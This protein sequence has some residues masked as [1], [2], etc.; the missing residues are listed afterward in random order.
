M[1]SI[2]VKALRYQ[3]TV[4]LFVGVPAVVVI[5]W[6]LVYAPLSLGDPLALTGWLAPLLLGVFFLPI[7]RLG[8]PTLSLVWGFALVTTSV[9]AAY[10]TFAVNVYVHWTPYPWMPYFIAQTLA[11]TIVVVWFARRASAISFRHAL[12][13]VGLW[14][15]LVWYAALMSPP[16]LRNS[17]LD[18]SSDSPGH[19]W[20]LLGQW[21][22][23]AVYAAYILTAIWV[24][25]HADSAKEVPKG[26][27][28]LL[29]GTLI[30][31]RVVVPE[32]T[33]L[34]NRGAF[35]EPSRDLGSVLHLWDVY[36][37]GWHGAVILIVY[38]YESL[39]TKL[40][41]WAVSALHFWRHGIERPD[42]GPADS[43]RDG[44]RK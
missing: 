4:L 15:A 27:I 43:R 20:A 31:K 7:R 18:W 34:M 40:F 8:R 28:V 41:G 9:G 39:R 22:D 21:I 6:R 24:L 17:G 32:I 23:Y 36:W 5:G 26:A 10:T 2:H 12:L 1:S 19:R 3:W 30:A 35:G 13:V 16:F 37:I 29:F 25:S 42:E 14:T 33:S 11:H 38:R 44:W